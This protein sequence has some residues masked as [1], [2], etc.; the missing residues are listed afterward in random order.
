MPLVTNFFVTLIN[1][2]LNFIITF[3]I[4]PYK[5]VIIGKKPYK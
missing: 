4:N 2:D 1:F 3:H 5:I